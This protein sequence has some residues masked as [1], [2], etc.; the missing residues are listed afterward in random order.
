MTKPLQACADPV[1]E[2]EGT[3]P[4]PGPDDE[5]RQ[6]PAPSRP[7][8]LAEE[9]GG[10][11]GSLYVRTGPGA[12]AA[13]RQIGGAPMTLA[14]LSSL[15]GVS[16]ATIKYYL[17][18][19]LLSPG[20]RVTATRAEYGEAHL[21]RLRFIRALI[22]VRRLSVVAAKRV[23]GTMA[24]Q[25]DAH[26]ILGTPIDAGPESPDGDHERAKAP[27]V[28]GAR[29]LITEMGWDVDTGTAAARSL[30]EILHALSELGTGIDWRTLLPYARLADRASEL[31][32]EQLNGDWGPGEAAERAVLV[33]LLL[34][35]AL[36]ALR[37][38]AVEDKS[39]RHFQ[40]VE[41]GAESTCEEA[42]L[43]R[44][45]EDGRGSPAAFFGAS[46]GMAT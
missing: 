42:A 44:R 35:P 6:P 45:P 19:G 1:A 40:G 37:R 4:P 26:R 39:V 46:K 23:L 22:G 31:D 17:R 32:I 34:E 24:R 38:L 25:P 13:S 27:G 29:R 11:R 8:H 43:R 16:A 15:S 20:R 10:S 21:H 18:E 2:G 7:H 36:L 5:R 28:A 41:G 3:G 33:I 30:G 14:E 9:P 12:P